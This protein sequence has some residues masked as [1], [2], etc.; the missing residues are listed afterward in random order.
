MAPPRSVLVSKALSRLLRH[1]AEQERVPI[2]ENGWVRVDHVL[3]WRG[4]SSFKPRVEVQEIMDGVRESEKARF[5]LKYSGK[6]DSIQEDIVES[7]TAKALRMFDEGQDT[8]PKRFLIRANQGHSIKAVNEEGLLTPLTLPEKV[9]TTTIISQDANANE[10][11]AINSSPS[12]PPTVVHG[13][14]YAAYEAILAEGLLKSMNRN[15][16]HF[17]SGPPLEIARGSEVASAEAMMEKMSPQP[18]SNGN[19]G[20][21]AQGK[22][23]QQSKLAK[24]MADAKVKS[25]MRPDAEVLIYIDLERALKA[26]M[27]WWRSEN[28]VILTEG[29][30][31]SPTQTTGVSAVTEGN[32]TQLDNVTETGKREHAEAPSQPTLAATGITTDFWLEVVEVKEGLGTLWK[33]GK[34]VQELPERLK[35]RALPIGKGRRGGRGGGGGRVGRARGGGGKHHRD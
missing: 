33:D 18:A 10:N 2:D 24:M 19:G 16:V 22:S 12:L 31:T 26:G 21:A 20:V 25:G 17:S 13:T 32:A 7:D 14:F 27:K 11:N 28:G 1:A 5:G 23:R 4:L 8:E 15:H 9:K 6:Q 29:L 3:A 30:T 35:G 34:V